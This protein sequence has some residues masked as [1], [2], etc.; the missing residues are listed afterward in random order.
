MY[1]RLQVWDLASGQ[2]KLTLTGHINSIRGLEVSPRHPY[3][4]SAAEDKKVLCTYA[5]D[6]M[7]RT[8]VRVADV[9]Y[10]CA[11]GWD[12]EY[13]KVIRSYHGHL[14]GVFSLKIH[15]TLDVLVTGGRD[16]VAR[17][18][19]GS[20]SLSL[21]LFDRHED[22]SPRSASHPNSLCAGMSM[23]LV[24]IVVVGLGHAHEEPDPCAVGSPGHGLGHGDASDGPAGHHGLERQHGQGT[25]C[26]ERAWLR[27]LEC[28][29]R[30][31]ADWLGMLSSGC[32]RRRLQLWDLAAGK[33]MT[34]LTNHKKG[35]RTIAK[36]PFVRSIATLL[37]SVALLSLPH[38][39]N[40]RMTN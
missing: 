4:F 30:T 29:H 14:S 40:K 7:A 36:S 28:G 17:V 37:L 16:A 32:S 24:A 1:V 21:G 8:C 9:L 34:T 2:L 13:N 3:L 19:V 18:R 15:P 27:V 6:S 10:V 39:P 31:H 33:V 12:L 26:H 23:V 20:L 11:I 25:P 22:E 5:R 38:A 35:V